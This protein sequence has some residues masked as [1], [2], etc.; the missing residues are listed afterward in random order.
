[1]T[2]VA[3]EV[4]EM[5]AILVF[6]LAV[7]LFVLLIGPAV[8]HAQE[9]D[10]KSMTL[11]EL[12]SYAIGMNV[13]NKLRYVKPL[14]DMDALVQGIVDAIEGNTLMSQEE[15]WELRREFIGT[16]QAVTDSMRAIEGERNKAEAAAFFPRNATR[17][18][19]IT[20]ESGLQYEVL[21]EGD[22][23]VPTEDDV[24][25]AHCRKMYLNGEEFASSHNLN[26]PYVFTVRAAIPG[27]REALQ[28]MKVGSIYRLYIPENLA[29]GAG[30]RGWA[31]GPYAS[32][33]YE[34]ELLEIQ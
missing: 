13:G 32:L 18:G 30:G 12:R 2:S 1:M 26:E 34:V 6:T 9:R 10:V 21:V 15:G 4:T 27:W 29:L 3:E 31:I 7:L 16:R 11:S 5:R 19:V 17:E 22:G 20:T 25:V 33:I 24:V 28:M 14:I 23:E 8:A